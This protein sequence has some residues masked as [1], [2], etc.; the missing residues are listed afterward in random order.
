MTVHKCWRNVC[1]LALAMAGVVITLLLIATPAGA[2]VPTC[3]RTHL[4]DEGVTDYV[5]ITNNCDTAQRIKVV[6]AFFPDSSCIHLDPGQKA[7]YEW[8]YPGRFDGLESC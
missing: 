4:R 8:R 6:L 2:Q 3:V 5:D 7:T 1:A